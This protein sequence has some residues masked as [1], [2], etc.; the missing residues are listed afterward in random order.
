M[1]RRPSFAITKRNSTSSGEGLMT[2]RYSKRCL[3]LAIMMTLGAA[4]ANAASMVELSLDK[5]PYNMAGQVDMRSALAAPGSTNAIAAMLG[6]NET[7][8]LDNDMAQHCCNGV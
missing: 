3:G 5:L 4:S 1:R 6:P 7:L 2:I 8:A